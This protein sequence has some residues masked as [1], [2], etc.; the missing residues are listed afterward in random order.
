MRSRENSEQATSKR[1]KQILGMLERIHSRVEY[2]EREVEFEE[3]K[4][5]DQRIQERISVRH[6]RCGKIEMQGRN[7]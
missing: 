4:R 5:S 3:C 1:E 6:K 7:V 2:L